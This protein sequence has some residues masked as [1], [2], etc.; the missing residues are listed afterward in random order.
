MEPITGFLEYGL[1]A[2]LGTVAMMIVIGWGL[3]SDS[4]PGGSES[5]LKGDK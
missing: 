5:L 4:A 2:I 1:A 3:S